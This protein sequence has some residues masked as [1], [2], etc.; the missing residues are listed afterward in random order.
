MKVVCNASPLISLARLDWLT[1]LPALFGE[2]QIAGEVY[3]EVAIAG[4]GRAAAQAVQTAPW[5]QVRPCHD[6]AK[7]A[8]WRILHSLGL[9][10]LATILL[11]EAMRADLVVIG[12]RAAR[13]LVVKVIGC[14]GL[15]EAGHRRGLVPDLRVVYARMPAA[16]VRVHPEILN[17]SLKAFGLPP[18]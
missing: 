14:V 3:H 13:R 16:G 1:L 17:R 8:A 4:A 6:A 15:L 11:A 7:L 9:G 2:V 12:E 5:L 10:E 18:L